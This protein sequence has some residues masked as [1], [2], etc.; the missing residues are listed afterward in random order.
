[1]DAVPDDTYNDDEKY[2]HARGWELGQHSRAVLHAREHFRH[3][4]NRGFDPVER[5]ARYHRD[6][7]QEAE[8][9][10]DPIDWSWY[11]G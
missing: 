4:N 5:A 10:L 1:M 8:K 2:E 6:L 11:D 9:P 3:A 7:M